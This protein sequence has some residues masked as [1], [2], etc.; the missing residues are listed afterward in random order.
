MASLTQW[1]W[2][3]VNS[4]RRWRTRKPG[5]LQSMGSQRIGH[6]F[7]TE[8]KQEIYIPLFSTLP[9]WLCLPLWL[10]LLLPLIQAYIPLG[11]ALNSFLS[12]HFELIHSQDSNHH[13]H[14]DNSQIDIYSS[15]YLKLTFPAGC[16]SCHIKFKLNMSQTII[17][18]FPY[19]LLHFHYIW[20]L[21]HN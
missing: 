10:F 12:P 17:I 6:D 21:Y 19:K 1:T 15:Y 20:K 16:P 7:V 4:G 18:L 11:I 14:A 13:F 9:L 8:K 2:V 5:V 3:W